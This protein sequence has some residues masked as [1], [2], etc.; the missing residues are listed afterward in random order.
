MR[1]ENGHARIYTTD[2]LGQVETQLLR[3]R[4]SGRTPSRRGRRTARRSPLSRNAVG[5]FDLWVMNADG[6]GPTSSRPRTD[7][8]PA[9]SPDGTGSPSPACRAASSPTDVWVMDADGTD[10]VS[11]TTM[12][13]RRPRPAPPGR[14]TG[15]RSCSPPP[16]TTGSGIEQYS[17]EIAVSAPDGTGFAWLTDDPSVNDDFRRRGRP[18]GLHR[19]RPVHQPVD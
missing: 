14:P 17:R 13:G 6:S 4:N 10:Q 1:Y 9:W 7:R 15:R 18:T 2:V 11:L 8:A 19:V 16:A 5:E 3:S 12:G